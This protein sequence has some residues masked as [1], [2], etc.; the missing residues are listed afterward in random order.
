MLDWKKTSAGSSA[1]MIDGA[2]RIGKSTI[3]ETFAKNEYDDY[4]VIDFITASKEIKENFDNIGKPDV[5][6]RNLFIFAGKELKSNNSVIIFD[7][8][9]KFPKAR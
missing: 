5:F 3:A 6:F 7:E 1:L 4:L 8:V 9:Q 2:R